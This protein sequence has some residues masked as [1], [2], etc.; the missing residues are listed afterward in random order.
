MNA[1]SLW[2]TYVFGAAEQM[3]DLNGPT[4]GQSRRLVN[5]KPFTYKASPFSMSLYSE[6]LPVIALFRLVSDEG[7]LQLWLA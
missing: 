1:H 7:K 3:L 6:M 2:K 5:T 4:D